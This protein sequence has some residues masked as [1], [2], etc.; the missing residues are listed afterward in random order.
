[1][2]IQ[3]NMDNVSILL[4][5]NPSNSISWVRIHYW[6]I[7]YWGSFHIQFW[8]QRSRVIALIESD[9]LWDSITYF[10]GV[11]WYATKGALSFTKLYS[12]VPCKIIL[13]HHL[14]SATQ[15]C[16]VL[17]QLKQFVQYGTRVWEKHTSSQ[18]IRTESIVD[19][20]YELYIYYALVHHKYEQ[21]ECLL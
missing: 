9:M 19:S 18:F 2:P 15:T 1:M 8:G 5:N 16:S 13:K 20:S 17:I 4:A 3:N 7:V 6:A 10:K 14:P 12:S 21:F 11:S